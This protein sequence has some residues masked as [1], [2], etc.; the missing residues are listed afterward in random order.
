M[1]SYSA[2]RA[3]IRNFVADLGQCSVIRRRAVP[4]NRKRDLELGIGLLF[5]SA[6]ESISRMVAERDSSNG[7]TSDKLAPVV[8]PDLA[9]ISPREFNEVVLQQS[10]R[11][12]LTGRRGI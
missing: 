12:N 8:P 11:L 10:Q 2:T 3:S 7:V 5:L 1:G 9:L 4:D 6:I